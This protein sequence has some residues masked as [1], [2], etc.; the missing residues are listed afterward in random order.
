MSYMKCS[1][2]EAAR[3]KIIAI[4]KEHDLM[5]AVMIA[6]QERSG[7]F[8]EVSPSWSCAIAEKTPQGVGIR[9]KCRREDYPS[10]QAQEKTLALTINGLMGMM[11]VHQFIGQTLAGVMQ[12][13]SRRVDIRSVAFDQHIQQAEAR[14]DGA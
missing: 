8:Q 12:M 13:I 3:V 6:D 14:E 7:F 1:N 10:E 9:V 2:M 4:L 11:H 5:G